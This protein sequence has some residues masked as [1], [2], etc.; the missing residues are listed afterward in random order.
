MK[1]ALPLQIRIALVRVT[2]GPVLGNMTTSAFS[3]ATYNVRPNTRIP[4]TYKLVSLDESK[5]ENGAV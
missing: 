5:H 3:K 1:C 4:G 2:I